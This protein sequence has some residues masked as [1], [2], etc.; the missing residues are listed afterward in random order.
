M[1]DHKDSM[2]SDDLLRQAWVDIKRDPDMSISV[3]ADRVELGD[4]DIPDMD[5]VTDRAA[6]SSP[7]DSF[8]RAKRPAPPPPSTQRPPP[9]PPAPPRRSEPPPPTVPDKK[10]SKSRG[11]WVLAGIA[12]FALL[13]IFNSLDGSDDPTPEGGSDAPTTVLTPRWSSMALTHLRG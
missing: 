3:D 9:P 10:S 8:V 2:S 1:A 4:V 11:R 6:S 5:D 13:R 7:V 12:V